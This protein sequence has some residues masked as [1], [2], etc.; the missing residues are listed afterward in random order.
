MDNKCS[1]L[2]NLIDGGLG[3]KVFYGEEVNILDDIVC[4]FID[5]ISRYFFPMPPGVFKKPL[6]YFVTKTGDF[7]LAIE[8]N[9]V[10]CVIDFPDFIFQLQ[11][12]NAAI[13][14]TQRENDF[15]DLI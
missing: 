5:N 3:V 7:Q 12:E 15:Y 14:Q 2:Q 10:E 9:R 6:I 1:I 4:A 11:G 8:E 13:N